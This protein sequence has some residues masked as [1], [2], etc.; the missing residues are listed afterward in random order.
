MYHP[1]LRLYEMFLHN[2]FPILNIV[3]V[4]KTGLP[5]FRNNERTLLCFRTNEPYY[6][7]GI[8]NRYIFSDE[9]TLLCFRT[10]KPLYIFGI[11]NE[12]LYVFGLTNL[13]NNEPHFFSGI[14]NLISFSDY[15][16][17]FGFRIIEPSE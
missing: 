1:P 6:V 13:R 8:T 9:R 12:P 10:N 2:Y 14:T 15:R 3:F 7:F 11:I 16:T 5:M 17:L 4:I